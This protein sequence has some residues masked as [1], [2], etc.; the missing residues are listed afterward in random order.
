MQSMFW[1]L[2]LTFVCLYSLAI[3]TTRMIGWG[4]IFDDPDAIPKET[5][6]MFATMEDSMFTLF[7]FMNG[8]EWHKVRP[9]LDLLPWTKPL[10][11]AFTI[12]GSWALLSVMTG[13]VSDHIQF[14]REEQQRE[15]DEAREER[16]EH[17]T[18]TLSQIFAAADK[19]GQGY[20]SRDAF[21]EIF[22]SPFQVRRLQ[23]A[24]NQ[25]LADV[26][27][28]FDWLDVE[29][30][31]EIGF[32]EFC[33]GLDCL[34]EPVTG[35]RLLKMDS[36]IKLQCSAM[37]KAIDST[38]SELHEFSSVLAHQHA[39][40]MSRIE[41]VLQLGEEH[42]FQ[43]PLG[44]VPVG[45]MGSVAGSD[46]FNNPSTFTP[47]M[48]SDGPQLF[49]PVPSMLRYARSVSS[50]RS[51]LDSASSGRSRGGLRLA[52]S[53]SFSELGPEITDF[54]DTR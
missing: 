30:R 43:G 45:A 54:D 49:S 11:V 4:K 20:L 12:C 24:I 18:M 6:E 40:L 44:S 15:D 14:V 32:R 22:K 3:L 17:L 5:Q 46:G 42:L 31:G 26:R 23:R 50:L 53:V 47:L 28:I 48:A 38:A 41:E 21:M 29:G 35:H 33:E 34:Q 27:R 9:L 1:V 10:F 2:V 13:V 36:G 8:H 16:R 19:T 51:G 25:P 52:K 7:A 39:E 37:Q